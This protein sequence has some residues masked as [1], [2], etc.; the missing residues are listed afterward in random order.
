MGPLEFIIQLVAI[1][2]AATITTVVIRRLLLGVG[3]VRSF[4]V[5]LL[6]FTVAFPISTWAGQALLVFTDQGRLGP[7]VDAGV[8]LLFVLLVFLW[9]FVLS[10]AALVVL[11]LILP[12]GTVPGPVEALQST[13]LGVRRIRR[14]LYLAWILS[15]SGLARALRRGP[16]SR[17]FGQALVKMLNRSGVTFIK[18]GQI[19]STRAELLPASLVEAL[20]ALQTTATPAQPAE[21]QQVL[22]EEWGKDV[23]GVLAEF[24][25]TPFAAASVAQVHRARLDDGTEVVVKVQRPGAHEQV[26]VDCDILLRF[27]RTAERRFAW[28]RAMGITALSR[29]LAQSLN[30]ELDY[31]REAQNTLAVA[32]ALASHPVMVTPRIMPE[33][34][35]ERVIVMSRLHGEVAAGAAA[36][37][38]PDTRR[39]LAQELLTAT[40]EAIVVH[41]VFHADLHPGNIMLLEDDRLGLLDFGAIGVIDA[42]TRQLLATLLLALIN[43]DN[44]AATT[45]LTAAFEVDDQID[46][47]QLQ[48][49]LGRAI[50]L[51]VQ[52]REATSTVF[53]GFFAVLRDYG[54][55]VPGDV[56]G[57]FRTLASLDGTLRSLDPGYGLFQGAQQALPEIV[58]TL[59]DPERLSKL[60]E[61]ATLTTAV[62]SRRV[63]ARIEHISDQLSRGEFTVRTRSFSDSADQTWLRRMLDDVISAVFAAVAIALAAIFLLTPDGPAVTPVLTAWHLAAA[64]LGFLGLV[65]ALRLVVRLFTRERRDP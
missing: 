60:T 2:G 48:R 17:E 58:A 39:T 21:I 31:R 54:I 42:E 20:A 7:D 16:E 45:A 6:I 46:R 62:I 65:L 25:P 4:L 37:L 11:E 55:T 5:S 32:G 41:G 8:A 40:I 43:D 52:T 1:L 3:W 12:S 27:A 10:V 29:G 51:L 49:D 63:P 50:T 24:D 28:A 19:L 36:R 61:A 13:R 22:Q 33:L 64:V 23:T 30:E 38:D 9:V 44:V 14:Y 59:A 15:S 47:A 56:A 18:L 26:Q 35:G 53:G 57:A 34:S